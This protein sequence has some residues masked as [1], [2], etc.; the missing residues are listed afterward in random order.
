MHGASLAI[1]LLT[2]RERVERT[3]DVGRRHHVTAAHARRRPQSLGETLD[4]AQRAAGRARHVP[5]AIVEGGRTR[6]AQPHPQFDPGTRLRRGSSM[7][8]AWSC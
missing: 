7:A 3:H 6:F 4:S 1:E 5:S 2:R 8:V